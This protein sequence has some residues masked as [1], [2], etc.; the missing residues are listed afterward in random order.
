MK[1]LVQLAKREQFP[2]T[3]FGNE[4]P[5]GKAPYQQRDRWA[6]SRQ[7]QLSASLHRASAKLMFCLLLVNSEM[8][9]ASYVWKFVQPLAGESPAACTRSRGRKGVFSSAAQRGMQAQTHGS[10]AFPQPLHLPLSSAFTAQCA[11]K[12]RRSAKIPTHFMIM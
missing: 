2:L 4:E 1:G 12:C 8:Q 6:W 10:C 9:P 5:E 11:V 3:S 7:R